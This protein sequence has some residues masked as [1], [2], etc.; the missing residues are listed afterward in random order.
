MPMTLGTPPI[1]TDSTQMQAPG[2]IIRGQETANTTP[3]APAQHGDVLSKRTAALRAVEQIWPGRGNTTRL[4]S[5]Q[6]VCMLTFDRSHNFL[7]QK[8]W[9]P[10]N[11]K[12]QA[13]VYE[14]EQETI[15]VAKRNALAKVYAC[16]TGERALM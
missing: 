9:H 5:D 7:N 1:A 3:A 14:A 12:N 16:T 13:R 6:D 15:A 10:L 4:T 11:F 8:P 2:A